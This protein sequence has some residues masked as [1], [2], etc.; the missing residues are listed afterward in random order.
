MEIYVG[1]RSQG[2]LGYVLSKKGY[3][4]ENVLDG[5]SIIPDGQSIAGF[6]NN[7]GQNNTICWNS[8]FEKNNNYKIINHFHEFTRNYAKTPDVLYNFTDRIIKERN[9]IIIIS[10]Q[11]GGGVIPVDEYERQW[12][13]LTG[14]IMCRL[15]AGADH[16]ERIICGIGQVIKQ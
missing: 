16:V 12:R 9:D 8:I 5:S 6:G 14:R 10:D 7:F 11:V 15:A 4:M 1:G 2:K 3:G 13:E